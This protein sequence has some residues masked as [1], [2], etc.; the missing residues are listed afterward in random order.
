MILRNLFQIQGM[1]A[2]V[3]LFLKDDKPRSPTLRLEGEE[4]KPDQDKEREQIRESKD[5]RE[6]LRDRSSTNSLKIKEREK[7]AKSDRGEKD[8][9]PK[10]AESKSRSGSKLSVIDKPERNKS[11]GLSPKGR[12]M[13]RMEKPGD[14]TKSKKLHYFE[15]CTRVVFHCVAVGRVSYIRRNK[16]R[17]K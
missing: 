11:G 9:L 13:S 10:S 16:N 14:L 7:S 15:F 5:S 4:T 17:C 1:I 6:N 2:H 8:K 12:R 3:T